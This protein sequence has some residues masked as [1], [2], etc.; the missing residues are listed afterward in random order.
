M[1]QARKV[2][3]ALPTRALEERLGDRDFRFAHYVAHRSDRPSALFLQVT[4]FSSER[5]HV[6][7]LIKQRR[8]KFA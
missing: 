7:Q 3:V 8:R 6:G 2:E 1:L 4:R 5:K